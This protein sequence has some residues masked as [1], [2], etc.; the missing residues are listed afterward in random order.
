MQNGAEIWLNGK[1]V[2]V[3]EPSWGRENYHEGGWTAFQVD[4][5]P[6]VKFGERNLLALRV[7]KNTKS[8]DLDSGD[9]FFLGGV[10]R[11]VTLFSVPKTH[12][13][14]VK[15]ETRL[16][17]GG[18]A[19]VKVIA[20]VAG[21]PASGAN[22]RRRRARRRDDRRAGHD[23]ASRKSSTSRASGRRSSRTFTRWRS[24]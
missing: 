20:T 21:G 22:E 14:D 9:Y 7:T 23:D 2:K 3:D 8:A 19:E 13:A 6:H 16:L 5:T 10:H 15:V 17:D 12:L 11:P 1:P 18:K 24:S 4:L